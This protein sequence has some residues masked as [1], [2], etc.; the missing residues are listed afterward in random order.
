M[1]QDLFS[2]Y[3]EAYHLETFTR[4][5][6]SENPRFLLTL[7]IA[8]IT[9][10][11][12]YLEY[13][14]SF[15]LSHRERSNPFPVWMH[16]FYLAHDSMGA[17]VMFMASKALGGFWFFTAAGIALLIWNFFEVYNLYKCI[18]VERQELWATFIKMSP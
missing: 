10:L 2:F 4:V 13:I 9:F 7:F 3:P 16:T 12:G 11:F 5:F 18:Y 17:I 6:S 15:L 14:Y 8:G 1:L